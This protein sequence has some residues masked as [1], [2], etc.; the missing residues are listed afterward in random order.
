[1][2]NRAV[3]YSKNP[4]SSAD[5]DVF[6]NQ[7]YHA[8]NFFTMRNI[9]VTQKGSETSLHP[10]EFNT[11]KDV[12]AGAIKEFTTSLSTNLS[13]MK[14]KKMLRFDMKFKS[15][16]HKKTESISLPKSSIKFRNGKVKIFSKFLKK[17]IKL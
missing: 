5:L 12:R 15:K 8:A 3:A 9:F 4:N 7:K 11:P 17:E 10:W 2:Y 16:K 13:K 14:R 6:F 1:V